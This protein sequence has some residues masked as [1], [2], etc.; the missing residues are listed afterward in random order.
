[1]TKGER[2][3]PF[4]HKTTEHIVQCMNVMSE[5]TW[6]STWSCNHNNKLDDWS[7]LRN[8]ARAFT[9]KP[10]QLGSEARSRF[11]VNSRFLLSLYV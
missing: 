2:C 10:P 3:D 9:E 5:A 6:I 7:G 11:A 8:I 4:L 1:M